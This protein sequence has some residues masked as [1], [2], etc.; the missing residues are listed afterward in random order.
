MCYQKKEFNLCTVRN[1]VAYSTN[2]Q[3]RA[4][5]YVKKIELQNFQTIKDFNGEFNGSVY[6]VTGE[7]ELGKS[8]LLKAISILLT[9]NRDEVLNNKSEKGFAKTII[10][11]NENDKYEIELRFTKANPRGTLS[12]TD[13]ATGMKSDKISLLQGLF[14]YQDFDANEFSQWSETAEGRRKQ[15]AIVKS[16]LPMEVQTR[17]AAIDTEI[18]TI[19]EERKTDNINYKN[20]DNF[21]KAKDT[22]VTVNEFDKYSEEKK[23]TALIDQKTETATLLQQIKEVE[24][25]TETRKTELANIPDNKVKVEQDFETLLTELSNEELEIKKEYDKKML[26]VKTK[27]ETAETTETTKLAELKEK[28]TELTTKIKNAE[29]WIKE[30]TPAKSLEAIQTEIDQLE[31]HNKM[32]RKV[33]AYKETQKKMEEVTKAIA[34]KDTKITTLEKERETLIKKSKLPISGLNFTD[35]GLIL[36][37]VPFAPGQVSTSQE[38][39]VAAKLIIA[40]NPT[41]KVFRVARGESL[42]RVKTQALI[43]FALLAGY[44]GFIEKMVYDQSDMRVEEYTEII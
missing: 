14:C 20:H 26:A 31:E 30:E 32:Y 5:M 29:A 7:N 25:R 19:K 23:I 4:T 15:V 8:T 36:N 6:F 21:L 16:L 24:Q 11:D 12:I 18:G 39:E 2:Q 33:V 35:D 43:D 41:V 1:D 13:L 38:M 17:I 22:T 40:K 28:E 10:G 42:G 9:G 27:R 37:G 34:T 44:Q 3:K